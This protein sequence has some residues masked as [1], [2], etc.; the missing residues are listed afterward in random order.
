MY[1]IYYDRKNIGDILRISFDS[2]HLPNKTV[3]KDDL[4]IS[5]FDEKVISIDINNFSK[6]TR[7]FFEGEIIEPCDEFLTLVNHI[8]INAG[9]APLE[10]K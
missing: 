4:K 1:H 8:L 10:A 3:L 9:L 2:E 5:Y 6:I 7:I